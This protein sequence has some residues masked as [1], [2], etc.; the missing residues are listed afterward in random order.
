MKR[1]GCTLAGCTVQECNEGKW[2]EA[3][4]TAASSPSDILRTQATIT[5]LQAAPAVPGQ[6]SPVLAYFGAL[7]LKG[8]LNAVESVEMS[9]I[10]IS[11]N[12]PELV[13]NWMTQGKLTASEP[14]GDLLKEVR[15]GSNAT[16]AT[17][18]CTG[19]SPVLSCCTAHVS[20][21][22]GFPESRYKTA[23]PNL[24]LQAPHGC[25]GA[26]QAFVWGVH[27]CTAAVASL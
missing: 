16:R 27:R 25:R 1:R 10:A 18:L 23:R 24:T 5:R 13:K 17:W 19:S 21:L 15:P 7:L 9:R 3:A 20:F 4:E 6:K 14:L 26:S 22:R 11:Q 8:G 2:K 12:K